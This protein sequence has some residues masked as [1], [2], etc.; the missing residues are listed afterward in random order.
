MTKINIIP[1]IVTARYLAAQATADWLTGRYPR[2]ID[3]PRSK[4]SGASR[5]RKSPAKVWTATDLEPLARWRRSHRRLLVAR[6]KALNQVLV[7]QAGLAASLAWDPAQRAG[8]HFPESG[9]KTMGRVIGILSPFVSSEDEMVAVVPR[10]FGATQ[11]LFAIP[12][13]Q[14]T[15]LALADML[16]MRGSVD[17]SYL[18]M[19]FQEDLSLQRSQPNSPVISWPCQGQRIFPNPNLNSHLV[20]FWT[21]DSVSCHDLELGAHEVWL[22]SHSWEKGA[23]T[24]HRVGGNGG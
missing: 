6:R 24:R 17:G 9:L 2:G 10:L 3:Y 20:A 7:A 15:T 4:A 5:R 23:E 18:A 1:S 16:H 21:R 12:E 8:A 22:P 14:D 11:A 13:V 19:F